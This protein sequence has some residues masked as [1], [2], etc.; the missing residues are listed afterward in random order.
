MNRLY[1]TEI[2]NKNTSLGVP[3]LS[4]VIDEIY[5]DRR[6]YIRETFIHDKKNI[7]YDSAKK[8]IMQKYKEKV[9]NIDASY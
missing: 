3:M 1:K 2:I 6:I 4:F 8:N 5:R 7:G 9:W